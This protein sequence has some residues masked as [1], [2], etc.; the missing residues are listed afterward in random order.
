MTTNSE[1]K[2]QEEK[3]AKAIEKLLGYDSIKHYR[4]NLTDMFF[5]YNQSE[6]S[7][8]HH[9]RGHKT[10]TYIYLGEFLTA[11]NEFSRK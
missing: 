6:L 3:I 10:S 5:D 8:C 7:D 1:Q 4:D 2:T 11:I 9:D